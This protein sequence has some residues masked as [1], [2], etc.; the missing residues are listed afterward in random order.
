VKAV[1]A[2]SRWMTAEVHRDGYVWRQTYERGIRTSDVEKIR[3][4][5]PNE[6]TGTFISFFPDDEIFQ[7][8]RQEFDLAS[9]H[10]R[11][12]SARWPMSRAL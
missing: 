3:K 10:S 9:K 5:K 12:V 1:N 6:P 4:L 8:V 2:L 11:I 7:G